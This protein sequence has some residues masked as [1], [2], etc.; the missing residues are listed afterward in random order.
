M[1]SQRIFGLVLVILAVAPTQSAWPAGW[2][3]VFSDQFNG[4]TLDR[5]KWAT[6]YIYEMKPWTDLWTRASA[7]ATLRSSYPEES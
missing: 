5:N 3:M 7:T 1:R 2:E 4:E 6:R